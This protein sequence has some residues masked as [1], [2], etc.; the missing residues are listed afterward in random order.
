LLHGGICGVGPK[1]VAADLRVCLLSDYAESIAE[2]IAAK[3]DG[4]ASSTFEFL[5]AF[6]ASVQRIA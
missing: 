2:W 6:C 1:A 5:L 3:R 4:R